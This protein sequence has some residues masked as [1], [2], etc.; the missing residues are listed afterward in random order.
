MTHSSRSIRLSCEYFP[1]KT[2]EGR[3][4]LLAA[5][6]LPDVFQRFN[7]DPKFLE[8][9]ATKFSVQFYKENMPGQYKWLLQLGQSVGKSEAE[10]WS[11][12]Q[13]AKDGMMW[14]APR[15]WEWGWVPSGQM[16][17]K[18]LLDQLGYRIPA[19]LAEAEKV[20]RD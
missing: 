11:T 12:Y 10:T 17:R 6:D 2:D 7:I 3:H 19:T 16:W 1:P 4:K 15:I 13:D 18:D 9:A 8:Q 20:C 14:G 5:N